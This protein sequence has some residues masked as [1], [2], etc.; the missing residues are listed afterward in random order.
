MGRNCVLDKCSIGDIA[1]CVNGSSRT[2]V[3]VNIRGWRRDR[4]TGDCEDSE[5]ESEWASEVECVHI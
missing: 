1:H 4:E 5:D 2:W 3:C